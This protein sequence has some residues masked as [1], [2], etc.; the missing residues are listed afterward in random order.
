M[1]ST[2][3]N[4]IS[5]Q[6]LL[7]G[8]AVFLAGQ[9]APLA[10]PLVAASGLPTSWKSAVSGLLLLGLPEMGILLAIVI[11]GRA[12]FNVLKSRLLGSLKETLLPSHVS[13]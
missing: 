10:I 13:R 8:G 9:L 3:A 4:S 2:A 12:G 6:R 7:A 1:G 11:L 5:K